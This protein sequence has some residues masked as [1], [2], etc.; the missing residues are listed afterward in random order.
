MHSAAMK[1]CFVYVQTSSIKIERVCNGADESVIE[2]VAF[3]A[4]PPN[5]GPEELSIFVVVKEGMNIISPDTLKKR[6]SRALQSNLNPLFEVC[7][8]F[9][10]KLLD[11]QIN[12]NLILFVY[13]SGEMGEDS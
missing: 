6:F 8:K 4:A 2:S 9:V 10:V 1:C 3:S 12:N 11:I 7:T 13:V 5:G